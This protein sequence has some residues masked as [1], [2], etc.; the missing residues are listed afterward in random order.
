MKY[1]VT[2]FLTAFDGQVIKDGPLPESPPAQLKKTLEVAC[3]NANPQEFNTGEQKYSVYKL[4]QKIHVAEEEVDLT[5]EEV[6][7]LKRL[8]GGCYPVAIVGVVY[9]ILEKV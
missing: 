7:L 5:S 2:Q 3:I 4:L 8:V 1:S 9:D 6:T